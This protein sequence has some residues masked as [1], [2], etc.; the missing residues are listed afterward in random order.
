MPLDLPNTPRLDSY[1]VPFTANRQFKAAPRLLVA[2]EA[3]L[4]KLSSTH[5]DA[6]AAPV[7][8]PTR[9]MS[10]RRSI[11]TP[12]ESASM[13]FVSDSAP[14]SRKCASSDFDTGPTSS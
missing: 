2:A 4:T 7:V 14:T 9:L 1:W 10:V 12:P 6:T 8:S 3:V 5:D 13:Q 11:P